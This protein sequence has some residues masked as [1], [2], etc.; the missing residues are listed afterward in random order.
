M[1][2]TQ[3]ETEHAIKVIYEA[4]VGCTDGRTGLSLT[5]FEFVPFLWP[6][7]VGGEDYEQITFGHTENIRYWVSL[8]PAD[9]DSMTYGS[10]RGS[11]VVF[12]I[13]IGKSRIE[14]PFCDP[15]A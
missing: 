6:H 11:V 4:Q 3:S 9:I 1:A 10:R 8:N 5:N 14:I 13:L 12:L 2:Q 7:S 15:Q